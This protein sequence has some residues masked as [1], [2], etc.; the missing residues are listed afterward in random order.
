MEVREME[1]SPSSWGRRRLFIGGDKIWLLEADFCAAWKFRQQKE[2]PDP[3]S[4][5]Q[6]PAR[7]RDTQRVCTTQL[8]PG[9]F[10][11]LPVPGSFG[12]PRS[13]VL[14]RNMPLRFSDQCEKVSWFPGC[15]YDAPPLNSAA[16]PRTQEIRK[17]YGTSSFIEHTTFP[18]SNKRG[19]NHPCFTLT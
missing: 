16:V 12:H 4:S 1:S 10:P 18:F 5:G 3:R 8:Y 14:N 6:V 2:V 15:F 9:S 13:S 19:N 7:F 17:L 11:D